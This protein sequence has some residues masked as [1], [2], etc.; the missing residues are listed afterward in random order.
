MALVIIVFGT[1]VKRA[2]DLMQIRQPLVDRY[3]DYVM[4]EVME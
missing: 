3:G 4:Q 1:A 2:Y